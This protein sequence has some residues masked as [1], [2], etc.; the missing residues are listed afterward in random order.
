MTS[1]YVALLLYGFESN[2]ADLYELNKLTQEH[3]K[4]S[5]FQASAVS[6]RLSVMMPNTYQIHH[7]RINTHRLD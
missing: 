6:H 7:A 4:E 3:T 2:V 5:G 1:L